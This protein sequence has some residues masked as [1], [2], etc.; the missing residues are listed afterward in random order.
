[1]KDQILKI[2]GVKSEK[3]FYKKFPTEESFMAKHGKQ[4]KKAAMGSQ[5]V[6]TQLKQLTDFSNPPQAQFG[7]PLGANPAGG[8]DWTMG[9]G[10]LSG[11][12]AQSLM[13]NPNLNP[14]AL[15]MGNLASGGVGTLQEQIAATNATMDSKTNT[16]D[17]LAKYA[18]PAGEVVKGIINLGNEKKLRKKTEANAKLLELANIANNQ[19]GEL[20]KVQYALPQVGMSGGRGTG[21]NYLTARDGAMIGGNLTEIQNT[22]NP[23]NLYSDLGYEPLNESDEVKQYQFGGGITPWGMIGQFGSGV[24]NAATGNNAGGQIGG[25]L[26]GAIGMAVGGPAGAAIGGALGTLGGGLLD[27]ESKRIAAAQKKAQRESNKFFASSNIQGLQKQQLSGYAEDGGWVSHDW[28]PQVITKFGDM[29]VSQIHSFATE[30]MDTL[31]TGGHITQNN[32]YPQDQYALG[33]QVRT[34]WGGSIETIANN[35]NLEGS[36]DIAIARGQL[37]SEK[38]NK[39]RSGVGISYGDTGNDPYTDYA[40]YGTEAATKKAS[41]EVQAGEP[42]LELPDPQTGELNAVVLGG[43][44]ITSDIAKAIGN[45]KFAGMKYQNAGKMVA[46]NDKTINKKLGKITN[47]INDL[48]VITPIDKL[49]SNSLQVSEKGLKDQQKINKDYYEGLANNQ[50][51]INESADYLSKLYGK[52]VDPDSISKGK[53][54]FEK[55]DN[56]NSSKYGKA[57]AKAQNGNIV[58]PTADDYLEDLFLRAK[59]DKKKASITKFQEAFNKYHPQEAKDIILS[60]TDVTSKGK[61]MKINDI[62]TLKNKDINTILN[63]NVDGKLGERTDA[64]Y[65]KIKEFKGNRYTAPTL[66]PIQDSS[67]PPSLK[68]PQ[69]VTDWKMPDILKGAVD[70]S[71]SSSKDK[72]KFKLESLFPYANQILDIVRPSNVRKFDTR[73]IAPEIA[74]ILLNKEEPVRGVQSAQPFYQQK[75][76]ELPVQDQLNEITASERA[77][78]RMAG[79]NPSALAAIAAQSAAAKSKVLGDKTRQQMAMKQA[80]DVANLEESK[81]VDLL[82]RQQY[83]DLA[84]K[85]ALARSNTK[86][87]FLSALK[88]MT[89]QESEFNRE[90]QNLAT[91]ENLYNFRFDPV[92]GKAINMNPLVA[93]NMSGSGTSS[94]GSLAP[95]LEYTYD[96]SG[97]VVGVKKSK[98]E[99]AKYG[100]KVPSRNGSIVKAI[101]NL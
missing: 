30:G 87:E 83:T 15:N 25:A 27:P 52:K 11:Q 90:K 101:K 8:F 74:A 26:G 98:D 75:I 43:I 18:G 46:E 31:R 22:Y 57:I 54:K 61:K 100:K 10:S 39:G 14:P 13:T 51:N 63:T 80:I 59:G 67:N 71:S 89:T 5:M 53:L 29:D 69:Q 86:A 17:Q 73:A 64:M 44:K 95:G 45:P 21:S 96:A 66:A 62:E 97:N 33:G 20:A 47:D 40:E 65:N 79:G 32:I 50:N 85:Q 34:H 38:D 58:G 94:K 84:A 28:Q 88:S 41:V 36:G 24:A 60:N 68:I 93:F 6:N 23:G 70:K 91:M 76:G 37:H 49:R 19:P 1:M 12:T 72:N 3:E 16:L 77:A 42:I 35:P 82:N 81:R 99:T 92:T 78:M 56:S 9:S 7:T 48:D 55:S 4:L 2:A